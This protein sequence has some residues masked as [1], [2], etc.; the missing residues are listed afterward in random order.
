MAKK[1]NKTLDD[2]VG[3]WEKVEKVTEAAVSMDKNKDDAVLFNQFREEFLKQ[4]D[5]PNF[6]PLFPVYDPN[7]RDADVVQASILTHAPVCQRGLVDNSL[8]YSISKI[9]SILDEAKDRLE[10]SLTDFVASVKPKVDDPKTLVDKINDYR[11]VLKPI[12]K[13]SEDPRKVKKE[14]EKYIDDLIGATP[15]DETKTIAKAIKDLYRNQ[16]IT[17]IAYR[18]NV[19]KPKREALKTAVERNDDW[20]TYLQD[21][22]KKLNKLEQTRLFTS[23]Y[24]EV[25]D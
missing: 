25:K 19:V 21:N 1:K 18:A 10:D 9:K 15:D 24:E 17:E 23:L 20:K 14:S 6:N 8:D 2:F 7:A 3:K 16:K 11:D 12:S 22:T 5:N 4:L 13:G